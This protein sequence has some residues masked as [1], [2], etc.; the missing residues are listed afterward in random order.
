MVCDLI[1]AI[2]LQV[3]LA[4]LL[5]CFTGPSPFSVSCGTVLREQLSRLALD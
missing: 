5:L 1:L 4:S 3:P 2:L